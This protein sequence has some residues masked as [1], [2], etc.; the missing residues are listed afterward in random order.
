[1]MYSYKYYHQ[2]AEPTK[3]YIKTVAKVNDITEV[4]IEDINDFLNGL[5]TRADYMEVSR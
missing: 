3:S 1:M 5:E 4:A 2:I